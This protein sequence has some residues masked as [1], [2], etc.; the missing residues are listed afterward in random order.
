MANSNGQSIKQKTALEPTD[1]KKVVDSSMFTFESTEQAE[2]LT[3]I[4]GQQRARKVMN[5]GLHVNKPGYNLYVSGIVGTGKT[6]FVN[7]VVNDFANREAK[8]F[9]WCYVNNFEDE[10]KPKVLKLPAGL[11]KKLQKSMENLLNDLKV[12][13]PSTFTED[14][15]QKNRASIIRKYK[16]KIENVYK[17]TDQT[18]TDY[19]FLLKQSGST[20]LTIPMGEDGQ[21]LSEEAYKAMD[22]K[23]LATM[24]KDS[25]KLQEIILEATKSIHHFEQELK[26]SLTGFDHQTALIAIDY[27]IDELKKSYKDCPEVMQH[28]KAVR[29]DLVENFHIFLPHESTQEEKQ[30]GILFTDE[31]QAFKK[32]TI[33]VLVDHSKTVGMPVISADNPTF[34]NLIGKVEYENRMGIM[35]TDFTKIK[36]GYLHHANGGYLIIQ[37]KDIFSKSQA[38]EGLKRAL[39]THK[40]QIENI[41]EHTSIIATASVNPAPI[42]LDVKVIIIG[43]M[44][45]YQILYTHDE[46]FRKLFK[47]RVD[48][49]IEMKYNEDNITALVSFIHTHCKKHGLRHFDRSA[50]AKIIEYSSRLAGHQN[51]LSTRFNLQVELLYEA[52]AW[53]SMMG[54]DLV[55]AKHIE[56]AI[57]EKI[58]RSNLYEEK[59]QASIDEGSVLIDTTGEKVGQVNGLAVYDLGQYRFGKPSRITAT[60]F[61][62]RK[63]FVNIERESQMSGNIHN[64]GVYILGG[65]LGQKFAQTYPLVVTAHIAF[66]QSYGGVDGD[67]AS[68]TE[69]YAILS[70]LAEVPIDQGLAVTGSVNQNG[71]IQPIGGVNE[72]IEGF[73][74]VCKS[75]GLTGTQGVLI[76]H[77]NVKNL[78]LNDEV[79]EAVRDGQFHIYKVQT[80]EEGIEI[81]TGLPA[82]QPDEHGEYEKETVYGKVAEKLRMF[83]EF[84]KEQEK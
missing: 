7:S 23:Q 77:Q 40:L 45:I 72:K 63:G 69:L 9:D 34:Y 44:D 62:G 49:D 20:I 75:K 58:Y 74:A 15:H 12:D 11:G 39:L 84:A 4:V 80:I 70:S 42:P 16:E 79:I 33:N 56:K 3:T 1:L 35:S 61:M 26:R 10:Y 5:F 32:Y 52:D 76:P 78:T 28:V 30:L 27:Q 83:M 82:G 71:E 54:D 59:V 38:W 43:N 36:P 68:S 60:T 6:S 57:Q 13:I 31:Q 81:L 73:Y 55:S 64:K 50:V 21:P 8:L 47:I 46:D 67:S 53:A 66:E 14:N 65:Y 41:G 51:K 17:Q 24:E 2:K 25:T 19:G 22:E 18:A 48:F 29:K 37:A